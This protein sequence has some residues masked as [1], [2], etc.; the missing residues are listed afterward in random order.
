MQL[1]ITVCL[2][3]RHTVAEVNTPVH[4]QDLGIYSAAVCLLRTAVRHHGVVLV[5]QLPYS[6]HA[7]VRIIV[8]DFVIIYPSKEGILY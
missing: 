2:G 8:P 6:C 1:M 5:R 3:L 7:S 4:P